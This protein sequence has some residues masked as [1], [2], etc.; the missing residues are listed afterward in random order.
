MN[1]AF[2]GLLATA[3]HATGLPPWEEVVMVDG[4]CAPQEQLD[5]ELRVTFARMT[6]VC[7]PPRG[8]GDDS[9]SRWVEAD[10]DARQLVLRRRDCSEPMPGRFVEDGQCGEQPRWRWEG[11]LDSGYEHVV[12]RD[13]GTVLALGTV[14]GEPGDRACP[15]VSPRVQAVKTPVEVSEASPPQWIAFPAE[16]YAVVKEGDAARLQWT[17]GPNLRQ[18]VLGE[19]ELALQSEPMDPTTAVVTLAGATREPTGLA[20][21]HQI[22]EYRVWYEGWRQRGVPRCERILEGDFEQRLRIEGSDE[23]GPPMRGT[24]RRREPVQATHCYPEDEV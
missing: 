24:A 20:V 9:C 19:T 6:G 8:P 1:L 18:W 21:R 10:L 11:R 23:L 4:D 5:R 12:G 7:A 22:T 13:F 17:P 16:G 3:A 14:P 2:A 15:P